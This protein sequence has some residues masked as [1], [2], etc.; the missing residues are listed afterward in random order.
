LEKR[1]CSSQNFW[2]NLALTMPAEPL[3]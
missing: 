1:P 2:A 3:I